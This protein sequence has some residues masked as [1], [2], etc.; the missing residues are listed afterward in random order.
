MIKII[1]S[2]LTFCFAIFTIQANTNLDLKKSQIEWK[3]KKITSSHNGTIDIASGNLEIKNKE[4]V[5]G[6]FVIDMNSIVCLD[7]ENSNYNLKLV[8]HL[9]SED[10][11]NIE[12]FPTSKIVIKKVVKLKENDKK[13]THNIYADLTIKGITK[14][15]IF[16]SKIEVD[17]NSIVTAYAEFTVD[18]SQYDVEFGSTTFFPN[19]ADKAIENDMYFKVNLSTK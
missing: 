12:K 18:R 9:K 13:W 10:F 15:I 3:G 16:S 2:T 17:A 14:E 4:I 11:F 1:I 7:I 8:N 5:G 19:L 6:E